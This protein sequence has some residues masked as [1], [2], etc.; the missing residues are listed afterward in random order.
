MTVIDNIISAT[1]DLPLKE[2][3]TYLTTQGIT[4]YVNKGYEKIKQIIIDKQ[5]EGK[6]AFVPNKEEVLFLEQ[7]EKNPDYQQILILVPNYKYIDLIRTGLLLREYNRRINEKIDSEK[8]RQQISR[9]KL[10]IIN[11][12]GGGRLLKIAKL[13]ASNFFSIILSYLYQ[14]KIHSYPENQLEEEFNELVE[15]WERCSKYVDNENSLEEV[16]TFCRNMV[17]NHNSK[18]FLMALYENQIDV[19]EKTIKKLDEEHLIKNN[20]YLIK[21]EKEDKKGM[22]P[23]IEVMF[24]KDPSIL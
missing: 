3:L 4:S 14:L 23:R 10:D 24:Y 11:R 8:N 21:I 17:K 1:Q 18:F 6:Y 2:A 16:L 12:P 9:I 5:N 22:I 20:D 13:P 7:A 15:E 19:V